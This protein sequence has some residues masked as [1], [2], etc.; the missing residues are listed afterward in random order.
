MT[1]EEAH[2]RAIL[3]ICRPMIEDFRAG[4]IDAERLK[5]DILRRRAE[6]EE[7]V[8]ALLEI[9]AAAPALCVVCATTATTKIKDK[10]YCDRHAR[11]V[12]RQIPDN[13]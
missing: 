13:P 8:R 5:K 12:P 6:I 4:L 9:A 11:L 3:A 1:K 2:D 10:D 7:H